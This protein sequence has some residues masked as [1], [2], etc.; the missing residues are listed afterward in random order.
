MDYSKAFQFGEKRDKI[1]LEDFS[2]ELGTS[3]G[4]ADG[5]ITWFSHAREKY[6]KLSMTLQLKCVWLELLLMALALLEEQF[7]EKI[8]SRGEDI[9]IEALMTQNFTI[10]LGNDVPPEIDCENYFVDKDEENM[11]FLWDKTFY[12]DILV[13]IEDEIK[14]QYIV[15]EIFSLIRSIIRNEYTNVS[16][17]RTNTVH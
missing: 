17:E 14:M 6:D 10:V 11:V 7:K 15:L 5:G 3:E 9:G 16:F 13:Q 2:V 1:T 8:T 12:N 4:F